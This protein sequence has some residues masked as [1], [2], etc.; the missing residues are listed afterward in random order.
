MSRFGDG[1]NRGACFI[2]TINV[3][4]LRMGFDLNFTYFPSSQKHFQRTAGRLRLWNTLWKTCGECIEYDKQRRSNRGPIGRI[5][6]EWDKNDTSHIWPDGITRYILLPNR[7]VLDN[8]NSIIRGRLTQQ[9]VNCSF[10]LNHVVITKA[11]D[12]FILGRL[13]QHKPH[14]L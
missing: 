5:L 9:R 1:V 11:Y 13:I 3:N 12:L 8:H 2:S 4:R 6:T 10:L 7:I 14:R